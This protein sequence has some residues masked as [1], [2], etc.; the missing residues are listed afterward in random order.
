MPAFIACGPFL[1]IVGAGVLA[2]MRA[3]YPRVRAGQ[4]DAATAGSLAPA[5]A[6][7]I[8]R[9]LHI[10]T[11]RAVQAA[12]GGL[13]ERGALQLDTA[14]DGDGRDRVMTVRQTTGLLRHEQLV[15]DDLWLAAKGGRIRLAEGVRILRRTHAARL[16][17]AIVDDLVEAGLVERERETAASGLRYAGLIVVGLGLVLAALSPLA[18]DAFGIWL[19]VIPASFVAVGALFVG[20]GRRFSS[21]SEAGQR[22]RVAIGK[23]AAELARLESSLELL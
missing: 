12:A 3:Q 6:S 23:R 9:D 14:A 10:S 15:A 17:R 19:L 16:R 1:L 22:A 20:A 8:R 21:L 4:D 18:I 5:L 13:I 7:A 11:W 2:L